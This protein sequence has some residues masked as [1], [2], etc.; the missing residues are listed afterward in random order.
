MFFPRFERALSSCNIQVEYLKGCKDIWARD[1]MPVQV[2]QDHFV[3]FVYDPDYLKYKKYR[4]TIPDVDAICKAIGI[5]TQKSNLIVDGGNVV[6]TTDKVIMCDKVFNENPHLS[7]KDLIKQLHELFQVDKVIFVPWDKNDIIGHADG[8]VR[9]IDNN[10]VLINDY[11]KEKPEY[12]RSFRMALHNTGLDWEELPYNPYDNRKSISAIGVYINFLQMKQA[13]V[14]PI[15][16]TS[17]DERT[18]RI[19]ERVFKGQKVEP[20]ESNEL[21]EDGGIINCITWNISV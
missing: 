19:L 3:Q 15:F 2:T 14:A 10:T 16:K 7:E 11:S 5:S 13:I 18:L 9:F 1:Y 21:A 20:V 17:D 12:Q 4:K 8:M 6:K